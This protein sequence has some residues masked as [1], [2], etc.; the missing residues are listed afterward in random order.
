MSPGFA[1]DGAGEVSGVLDANMLRRAL[2]SVERIQVVRTI[3]VFS[4]VQRKGVRELVKIDHMR[5]RSFGAGGSRK[6]EY[7]EVC[8]VKLPGVKPCAPRL[9]GVQ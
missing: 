7:A 8:L 1:G 5:L 9:P 2:S 3:R 4:S 6:T